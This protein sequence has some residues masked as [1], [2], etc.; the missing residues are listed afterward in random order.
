MKRESERARASFRGHH[1]R[2]ASAHVG[3]GFA[4]PGLAAHAGGPGFGAHRPGGAA[5]SGFCFNVKGFKL[6]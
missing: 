4:G 3:A 2:R 1:Q 6:P 5:E